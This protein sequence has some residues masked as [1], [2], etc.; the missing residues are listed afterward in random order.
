MQIQKQQD[1]LN[2]TKMK[3]RW[4]AEEVDTKN[5]KTCMT[6]YC[7]NVAII[8]KKDKNYYC[9]FCA[10]PKNKK[11]GESEDPPIT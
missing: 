2:L 1:L 4:E 10:N 9:A 3:L 5:L 6:K 11:K 7:Y 8:L